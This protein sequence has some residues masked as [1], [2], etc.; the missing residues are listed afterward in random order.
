MLAGVAMIGPV[1][2]WNQWLGLPRRPQGAKKSKF[3]SQSGVPPLGNEERGRAL[4]KSKSLLAIWSESECKAVVMSRFA[5]VYLSSF[6]C[7]IDIRYGRSS[8][9]FLVIKVAYRYPRSSTATLSIASNRGLP[10]AISQP[11]ISR[12]W[13][14]LW[15]ESKRMFSQLGQVK[16]NQIWGAI[17]RSTP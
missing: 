4:Q 1:R 8:R 14:N 13:L 6:V 7:L 15:V 16:F 17:V 11:P 10:F 3:L 9:V 2:F 12:R 5:S